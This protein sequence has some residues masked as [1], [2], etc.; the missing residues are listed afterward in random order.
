MRNTLI[1][2]G[3]LALSATLTRSNLYMM[4]P[5]YVCLFITVDYL[6]SFV[7][8]PI[9]D[10]TEITS[11]C[12][13]WLQ[14][15]LKKNYDAEGKID[16][17]ESLFLG[18]YD[19][20]PE[21]ATQN[22]FKHIF[23]T[24]GL[25]EGMTILD[26]GCGMGTWLEYCKKRGVNGV[27]LTLSHEQV[28]L[29]SKKGLTA[30]KHDY[31]V[32]KEDFVNKFDAIT[33]LGSAEHISHGHGFHTAEGRAFNT[34]LSVFKTMKSYLKKDAKMLMTVLTLNKFSPTLY[35]L[36]Q[37]YVMHRHYGGYYA[38]TP[39]IESTIKIAG[40][41]LLS[42]EDHTKDYH[43]ISVVEPTHFGHWTIDL[44]EN[45]GDKAMYFLRGLLTD[46]FLLHHWAYNFMDTWMWQLGEY[47]TTPLTDE[48]VANAPANLK[49]FTI[50]NSKEEEV[51]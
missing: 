9:W 21:E 19:T 45:T 23:E 51:K 31:R 26:C 34:Y 49:Y 4:F 12:Y 20:P 43:W 40:L 47:Q 11:N 35:N 29:L 44:S 36:A 2:W 8:I 3:L 15:Y 24:L 18:K 25:K 33:L 13:D 27:G 38:L 50:Q 1:Y 28:D 30:Y 39:T 48:Q 10:Q 6:Y 46:P 16:L 5:V 14:H 32:H 37:G 42:T 17:T 22:K 7:G 41:K